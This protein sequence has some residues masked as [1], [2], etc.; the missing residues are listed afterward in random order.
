MNFSESRLNSYA[1]GTD[2]RYV[3]ITNAFASDEVWYSKNGWATLTLKVSDI[4]A[5]TEF[6]LHNPSTAVTAANANCF[7]IGFVMASG[8]EDYTV[9]S[10]KILYFDNVYVKSI[11]EDVPPAADEEAVAAVYSDN[12]DGTYKAG[13]V[14]KSIN[15]SDY[16][17]VVF[18]VGEDYYGNTVENAFDAVINGPAN[19]GVILNDATDPDVSVWFTNKDLTYDTTT[20]E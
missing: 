4:L 6:Q 14:F 15:P 2:I 17:N 12:G 10:K 8:H 19:I 16:A 7:M 20:V 3:D 9:S 11:T 1:Y 18:K 5:G 13:A